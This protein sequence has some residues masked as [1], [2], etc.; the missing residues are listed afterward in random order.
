[1]SYLTASSAR[2]GCRSGPIPLLGPGARTAPAATPGPSTTGRGC[3]ASSILGSEGGSYYA[4]RVDADARERRGGRALPRAPTAPRAVARSSRISERGPGAEERPGDLRARDGGGRRRRGDARARRSRR[5]RR[6]AARARTC[7]SSRRSSRASAAGAAR[8]GARSAAGTRRGRSDALAYQAV[9]YRQRDGRDAPRPAAARPPGGAASSAG[10]PT[11]D[12]VGRAR[13]ACSSGSSAAARPTACRAWSRASPAPRRRRRRR[14]GRSARP[15]VRPAA[16]GAPQPS[17]WPRAEVWEALLDD[18]PMTALIRNLAT[19]TRV[20]VLAPGSAG[21]AHGR[22]AARRRASASAARGCTRSP[23][24]AA[25]RTYAAGRG[26]RGRHSVEPGARDRRRARR[27]V[28]HGVR[29]RRAD[30]QAPAARA[31]R[32]GLDGRGARSPACR[33]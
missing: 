24:L 2:A 32:V 4:S 6:S 9:K 16:R 5:C 26:V 31:R 17:T 28:L 15:R 3:A 1:M 20:G 14:D 13:A 29:E 19:M 23:L 30:G 33:A 7:S 18:M 10:N 21:T 12:A 25:L 8:C 22:G 11:L 27:R